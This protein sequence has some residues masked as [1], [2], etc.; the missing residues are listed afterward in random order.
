[1][2]LFSFLSSN[3]TFHFPF[4]HYFPHELCDLKEFAF[5]LLSEK[6]N[7][8]DNKPQYCYRDYTRCHITYDNSNQCEFMN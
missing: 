6:P 7:D 8:K 3:L 2:E 5:H 4:P 1:M